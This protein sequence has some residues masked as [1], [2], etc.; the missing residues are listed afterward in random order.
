M[1]FAWGFSSVVLLLLGLSAGNNLRKDWKISNLEQLK[2]LNN[3]EIRILD[4][5]IRE[6]DN[7]ATYEDG[8]R[9]ALIR[10]GRGTGSYADGYDAAVMTIGKGSYV[11]GYHN[12]IQQFGYN[13]VNVEAQQALDKYKNK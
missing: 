9:D 10:I 2:E 13:K 3:A 4:Q 6:F 8:Y 5:T 7:K 12:A 11:D 1:K